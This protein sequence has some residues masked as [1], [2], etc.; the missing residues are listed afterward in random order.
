MRDCTRLQPAIR[1]GVPL[2]ASA[3]VFRPVR[4]AEVDRICAIA[5]AAWRPIF[6]NYRRM[7]GDELFDTLYSNWPQLKAEQVRRAAAQRPEW[8]YVTELAG[9]IIGFTTFFLDPDT[10]VGTIG[11][12]AVDP[13]CQAKGIGTFQHRQVLALFRRHGMR[14]A[15]V[16]TGLDAS[17][18]PARRSYEKAGFD[19][20]VPEVTYYQDLASAD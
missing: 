3:P 15:K 18:A 12:N 11:N 9:E 6:A 14:F 8:V 1:E 16:T 5:V 10:T 13:D 20:S 17:H 4:E 7:L 19:R 2:S